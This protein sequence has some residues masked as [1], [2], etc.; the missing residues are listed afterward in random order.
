MCRPSKLTQ[1]TIAQCELP[2]EHT[3]TTSISALASELPL[4]IRRDTLTVNYCL[5]LINKPRNTN[6]TLNHL[7]PLLAKS[8]P[9][10]PKSTDSTVT[11]EKYSIL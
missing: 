5:S 8:K 11:T 7:L 6:L 3:P 10:V 2:W 1:H 9:S 4:H